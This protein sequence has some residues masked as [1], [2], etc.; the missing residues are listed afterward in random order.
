MPRNDD[1]HKIDTDKFQMDLMKKNIK[2]YMCDI[3]GCRETIVWVDLADEWITDESGK[4]WNIGTGQGLVYAQC[5]Y[6][7]R[8]LCPHPS[9]KPDRDLPALFLR[10]TPSP[11]LRRTNEG[12]IKF[13]TPDKIA[14]LKNQIWLPEHHYRK[15]GN[16]TPARTY[17]DADGK[18]QH[19][20]EVNKLRAI[21][22]VVAGTPGAMPIESLGVLPYVEGR[23]T[24]LPEEYRGSKH[25][26][27]ECFWI[28]NMDNLRSLVCCGDRK[29]LEQFQTDDNQKKKFIRHGLAKAC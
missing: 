22:S 16:Y 9:S 20:N 28:D 10:K 17:I 25:C 15:Y 27:K 29:C 4:K 24:G 2:P 23:P 11:R 14:Q 7:H 3:P 1:I 18:R 21:Q 19:Y 6:C 8:K 12:P 5:H 13:D 26:M